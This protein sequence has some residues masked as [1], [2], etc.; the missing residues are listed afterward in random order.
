MSILLTKGF[1]DLIIVSFWQK[2]SF[3][4][5]H[6]FGGLDMMLSILGIVVGGY[7]G[8]QSLL[9]G[10]GLFDRPVFLVAILMVI[11]GGHVSA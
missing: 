8:V 11:V 10:A 3:R 7:L 9:F 4:T 5:I 1:L 2:Y 6:V